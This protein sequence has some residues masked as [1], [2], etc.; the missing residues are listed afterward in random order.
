MKKVIM[1]AMGEVFLFT[2]TFAQKE[3][4]ALR[5]SQLTYGGTARFTS[6]AGAFGA[7]GGAFSSLSINPA[8]IGIYRKSEFTFT[9]SFFM[10]GTTSDYK[11]NSLYDYKTN[12]N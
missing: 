10:Q 12:V 11:G 4:D 8:G 1:L 6:M 9:P 7:L 5:Y 2:L 3:I